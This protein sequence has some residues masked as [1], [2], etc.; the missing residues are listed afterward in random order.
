MNQKQTEIAIE[1]FI[2]YFTHSAA[3]H[4]FMKR[5]QHLIDHGTLQQRVRDNNKRYQI[6][7]TQHP[8]KDNV[9]LVTAR[10]PE[11]RWATGA[12]TIKTRPRLAL[13]YETTWRDARI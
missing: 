9:L 10:D 1:W 13:K 3:A 6:A 8:E 11:A 4:R 2:H 5:D 12:I 7:F